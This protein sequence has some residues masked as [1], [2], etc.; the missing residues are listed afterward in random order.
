VAVT[1]A[2]GLNGWW[3]DRASGEPKVGADYTFAFDPFFGPAFAMRVQEAEPRRSLV[4]VSSF[5]RC[6]FR[7]GEGPPASVRIIQSGFPVGGAGDEML[8]GCRSGWQ[9]AFGLLRLYV[10]DYW[11]QPRQ[12][13]M[14]LREVPFDYAR[15]HDLYNDT[16]ERRKWLDHQDP[17]RDV[18][19]DTGREVL[20]RWDAVGGA[21][22]LKAF[23]WGE[24]K[25]YLCL[26]AHSWAPDYDLGSIRSDLEDW[27]RR[28][29]GIL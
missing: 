11:E 24:G 9:M 20:M 26:R 18:L 16:K 5:A 2:D 8:A 6:D 4:L 28:I 3:T 23:T 15:V 7:F 29:A 27:I 21:L 1:T 13:V 17:P 25:Q 10:E 12:S 14:V 19:A 22:E